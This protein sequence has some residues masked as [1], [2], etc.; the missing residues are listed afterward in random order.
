ML[1]DKLFEDKAWKQMQMLLDDELPEKKGVFF[2]R[3]WYVLLPLLL[4]IGIGVYFVTFSSNS[5]K[6]IARPAQVNISNSQNEE[7]ALNSESQISKS[8]ISVDELNSSLNEQNVI[9][10]STKTKTTSTLNPNNQINTPSA[11]E[12]IVNNSSISSQNTSNHINDKTPLFVENINSAKNILS[13][14]NNEI[15]TIATELEFNSGINDK[16][17]SIIN[18]NEDVLNKSIISTEISANILNDRLVITSELSKPDIN[19]NKMNTGNFHLN[20]DIGSYYLT[21]FRTFSI[22][23]GVMSEY[24]KNQ[25]SWSIRLG[26]NYENL[27]LYRTERSV[28]ASISNQENQDGEIDLEE[29]TVVNSSFVLSSIQQINLPIQVAYLSLIHISEPTRPY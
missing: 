2:L 1:D 6:T 15:S 19:T 10:T 12:R 22:Y 13:N 23:A 20:L 25:S 3:K 17:N 24:R 18:S 7:I 9:N 29:T 4:F 26:L 8:D 27:N 14:N 21:D 5:D 16:T 11:H 28:F